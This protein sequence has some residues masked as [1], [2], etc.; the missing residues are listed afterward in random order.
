VPSWKARDDLSG[1]QIAR[2]LEEHVAEML[3]V[4]P[5]ESKHALDLEALRSPDI[6]FWPVMDRGAWSAA[7]RS[8][9]WTRATPR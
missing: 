4:S 9:G 1:P 8:S 2:F 5:P 3:S 6:T 7:G